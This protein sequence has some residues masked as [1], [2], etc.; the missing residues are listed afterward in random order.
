[1]ETYMLEGSSLLQKAREAIK[2]GKIPSRWLVRVYAG[3]GS[4]VCCAICDRPVEP[5]Q[6]E[7][8]LDFAQDPGGPEASARV[9]REC[10]LAWE[11][12]VGASE[13]RHE[14]FPSCGATQLVATRIVPADDLLPSEPATVANGGD[15]PN[16]GVGGTIVDRE[17]DTSPG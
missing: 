1:M 17:P 9:H 12:L 15:L 7:F 3:S 6:T 8:E 4:G 16:V 2:A 13:S 10:C 5:N 11:H 14:A